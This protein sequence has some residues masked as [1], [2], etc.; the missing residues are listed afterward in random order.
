VIRRGWRGPGPAVPVAVIFLVAFVATAVYAVPLDRFLVMPD[1]LIYSKAALEIWNSPP[2]VAQGSDWFVSWS[3]LLPLVYS[4]PLG[5]AGD[6]VDGV[7]IAHLLAAGLMALTAVP[8]YLL[9]VEVTGERRAG[10][11]VAALC[12]S[13][14]W[15]AMAGTLMTEVFAY[16]AFTWAAWA[17]VRAC[18]EPSPRR[19]AHALVAALVAAF[20]RTQLVFV[21][22]ALVLA[23]LVCALRER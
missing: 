3:Q 8:A 23:V 9:A 17:A 14:P 6:L 15:M 5:A 18:T 7:R 20:A 21:P 19:D 11:L 22:A 12:V 13:V 4:I 10:W 1:E 16:P 2:L